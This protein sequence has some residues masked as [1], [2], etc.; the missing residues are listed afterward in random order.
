MNTPT[1]RRLATGL[2]VTWM[3][4]AAWAFT[5]STQPPSTTAVPGNVMLALSVEFPT[6]LQVSYDTTNY[7][8]LLRYEGYFD[9]RK[10]YTYNNHRRGV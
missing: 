2:L 7:N 6:G 4:T 5:P 1:F 8:N 3:A 9:N 10:C